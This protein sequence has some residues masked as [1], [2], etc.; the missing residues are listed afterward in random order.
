MLIFYIK[1]MKLQQPSHRH[2]QAIM[3]VIG[4]KNTKY[5]VLCSGAICII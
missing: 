1:M 2:I 4:A 3:A 5:P